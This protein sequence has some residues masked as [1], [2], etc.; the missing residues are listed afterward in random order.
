MHTQ[1]NRFSWLF[2][3]LVPLI[4]SVLTP[5]AQ[6]EG[7]FAAPPAPG[8]T[9]TVR[10]NDTLWEIAN[11][12]GIT[13]AQLTAANPDANPDALRP[14]QTL[15]IPTKTPPV[16]G[17]VYTVKPDDTLWNI[18]AKYGLFLNDL[19][20]ANPGVDPQRLMA[21]QTLTIPSGG[22]AA[23]AAGA[24]P[25]RAT[26]AVR[27][28]DTLWDIAT[29][30]GLSLDELLAANSGVDPRRLM[31]GQ[32]LVIPGITQQALSAA[33]NAPAA[34]AAPAP[35]PKPAP[36]P[37]TQGLASDLAPWAQEMVNRI[38]EKRA[39]GG[40]PALSWNDQLANAAQGHAEDC[41]RRNRG[42]HVGSDGSRLPGRLQRVG[43]AFDW[44]GE[45][46]ANARSVE[47]AMQMWWNEP[48]GAD[49]HV[50]NIM[51]G[52]ATEIGIGVAKG[53]W[54][55]YFIADFGSR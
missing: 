40:L 8:V 29:N 18:A 49:P 25:A 1:N 45:N 54:G 4:M 48:R 44:Q 28:D 34:P 43:Y 13:V 16:S 31:A 22:G 24:A 38:N 36:L 14:G 50:R 52:R 27:P 19:L 53:A 33:D 55:Y 5:A 6:A 35:A 11:R 51:A 10:A 15:T 47:R 12:Y 9:Y 30:Y 39:A 17:A 46:W 7:Q 37:A 3:V 20:A 32:T 21:G 23:A 26:Y 2:L 41:A 42:S